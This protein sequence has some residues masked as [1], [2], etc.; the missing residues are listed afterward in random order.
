[1][2]SFRRKPMNITSEK[3]QS[4]TEVIEDALEYTCD[5]ET[6]SGEMAWTIV[7]SLATAKLLEM[8]GLLSSD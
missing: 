8:Q 4:L 1:M 6:M 5:Q 3:L 7:E 2:V